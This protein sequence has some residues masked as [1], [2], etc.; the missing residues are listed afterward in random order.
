[1]K[2]ITSLNSSLIIKGWILCFF[3]LGTS[4]FS[5]SFNND[6]SLK[7]SI[8]SIKEGISLLLEDEKVKKITICH[9]PPGNP[10]N[11]QTI[12]IAES[13]WAA[14]EAHGD[15]LGECNANDE[16]EDDDQ[17][18]GDNDDEGDEN[19]GDNDQDEDNNNEDQDDQGNDDNNNED[20][21]EN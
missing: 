2:N 13:A 4:S 8:N 1:M 18:E 14:H 20:D 16:E 5:Y 17:E 6:S 19:E 10:S 21:E 7:E 3:L 12:K 9:I 11:P 15:T